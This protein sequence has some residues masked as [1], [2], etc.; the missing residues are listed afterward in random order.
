MLGSGRRMILRHTNIHTRF[1]RP[2][3]QQHITLKEYRSLAWRD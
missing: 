3:A 2:T 1:D